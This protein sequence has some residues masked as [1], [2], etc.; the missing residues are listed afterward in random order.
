MEADFKRLFDDI[1]A[2]CK[3]IMLAILDSEVGVNDKVGFNTLSGSNMYNT[4]DAVNVDDLGVINI[5]IPEYAVKYVDGEGY[6]WARRPAKDYSSQKWPPVNVIAEWASRKGI[7]S[8]NETIWKICYSIWWE[9]IKARPF[10]EPTF[11]E[12]DN[13]WDEWADNIFNEVCKPLDSFF[14]AV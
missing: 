7:P 4:I 2:Q 14:G 13:R 1:A 12:I 3:A 5:L 8:D 10:I 9:G 6:E 11:E